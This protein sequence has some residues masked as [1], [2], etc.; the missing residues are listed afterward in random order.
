MHNTNFDQIEKYRLY[1][2]L[3]DIV[4]P[5][6]SKKN[7]SNYKIIIKEELIP[8]QI[9]YPNKVSNLTSII[10]FVHGDSTITQCQRQYATICKELAI[11][12]NKTIIALDYKNIEPGKLIK[13]Y[14]D[15]YQ[16]INYL[17]QE[18]IKLNIKE[19]DITLIGDST[20]ASALIATNF[21]A[22]KKQ[23]P[24]IEK[25]I[26]LY[27]VIGIKSLKSNK[28]QIITE[29]NK[30]DEL[31]INRLKNY[32]NNGLK[33]KKG[34]FALRSLQMKEEKIFPNTLIITGSTD[35]LKEE[36]KKYFNQ[37]KKQKQNIKYIEIPFANHGF[38]KSK[39]QELK[40]ELLEEIRNF[41]K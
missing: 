10:I 5:T 34:H 40:K 27:P 32:F 23:T 15:C 28:H 9:F 1:R 18:L 37:Q 17:Y 12:L 39:D 20:G 35:P 41:I 29:N 26:L 11:S 2:N 31:T 36:I 14:Q 13:F 30:I 16:T 21:I 7:I 25:E 22:Q 19:K 4:H 33:G 8:L 38:L 6:I 24:K 3:K